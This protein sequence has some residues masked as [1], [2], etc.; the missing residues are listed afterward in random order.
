MIFSNKN[1]HGKGG[2]ALPKILQ[3]PQKG[4]EP[5]PKKKLIAKIEKST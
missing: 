1:N 2:R 3:K 5:Y 4:S